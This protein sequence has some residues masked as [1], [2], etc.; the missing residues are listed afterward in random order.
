MLGLMM[1][2]P[3]LLSSIL[4]YAARTFPDVEIVSRTPDKPDHRTNYDLLLRR[5]SQ[6]AHAL[7]EL[8]VKEGD[9]VATLAWNGF[10]HLEFYY[11]ISGI[12]AVCHTVNPRLFIEQI[13]YIINHAEGRFVF[14]DSTFVDIVKQLM[15][16]CPKV[17]KWIYL[18]DAAEAK[19]SGIPALVDYEGMLEGK[20]EIFEWPQFD[21]NTASGLCYTSG[22]T[23]NPKGVL[24]SHR[25]G[26]LH[27]FA[28]ALPDACNISLKDTVAFVAPMFHAMSWGMPY[29]APAMGAKLVMPG[30]KVDGESLHK[31]FEQEGV[32]FAN[33]VPT[34]WLGYAQYL[35]AAGVRPSTLKRVLMGGT[36]CPRSLMSTLE[37]DYGIEVLH[38]WGMTETSPIGTISKLQT[39]H[40]GLPKEEQRDRKLKQGRAVF[41]VEIGIRDDANKEL[42]HD[43]KAFGDLVIRGPWIARAYYKMPE[44]ERDD[45]WFFTGDVATIDDQGFMQIT[46]RSKDVI[47]SGGEWIS[48][49][50][51][52]NLAMAHPEIV[53][54]AVIGVAHP[55]WDERPL[56]IAVRRPGSKLTSAQLLEFYNGKIA[57]WWM[58]D[59]VLFV[60][61]LP[62][63]ATGKLLKTKLRELY[64]SHRLPTIDQVRAG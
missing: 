55:K 34:V 58:P 29:C 54:A 59:D 17:E 39:G 38:V 30:Q 31:I 60:E 32:T 52:E 61:E 50:E 28:A 23:G 19:G 25:S 9:R 15:V 45:G 35:R 42:P 18:G 41:G 53:E 24:Y 44:S 21:E 33:G 36:A 62:H 51:L 7:I 48:S 64:G 37:D 6:L 5:S 1:R 16:N 49:I 46:D 22:T 14:F 57:K 63:G 40:L 56:V 10:R 27:S 2:T 11:G 20:P 26:V 8:G 12:G 3:L 13:V 47:K 4:T 43:G